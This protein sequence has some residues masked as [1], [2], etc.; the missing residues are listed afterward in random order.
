MIRFQI[1]K[2]FVAGFET[3]LSISDELIKE[4]VDFLNSV[5]VGTGPRT[6]GNLFF[7][8]FSRENIL[9]TRL[10][11][12]LYSLG[13]FI[14]N[15]RNENLS[16]EE[17]VSSLANS[18]RDQVQPNL[19]EDQ[20]KKLESSLLTILS[21]IEPLRVTFKAF[22]LLAENDRVVRDGHIITDIRILFK[23][24]IVD[25]TRYGIIKHQLRLQVEE[26][27][28]PTDYYFSLSNT[29]LLK[30]QGQ[31]TRALEKEKLIRSDYEER[32]SFINITE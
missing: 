18:Y 6:F 15:A 31:I 2:L 10:A 11:S 16:Q 1:P 14:L 3:L 17:L 30:L 27:G 7:N 20:V 8:K 22:E 29:D 25:P 28:Q 13:G 9:N 19:T 5:P 24:E 32:I 12:T 23:Q 4:M 21:A 26:D